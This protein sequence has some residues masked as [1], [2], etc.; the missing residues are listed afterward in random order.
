MVEIDLL[1][2][3]FIAKLQNN[4]GEPHNPTLTLLDNRLRLMPLAQRHVPVC[5]RRGRE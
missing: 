3:D 5:T 1:R 4:P 2:T